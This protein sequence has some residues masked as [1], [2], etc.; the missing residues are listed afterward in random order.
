MRSGVLTIQE[1]DFVRE[2]FDDSHRTKHFQQQFG[3]LVRPNIGLTPDLELQRHHMR[4]QRR[5]EGKESE[6]SEGR[7]SELRVIVEYFQMMWISLR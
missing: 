7:G 3:S 4:L 1:W 2:V 5:D 6:A